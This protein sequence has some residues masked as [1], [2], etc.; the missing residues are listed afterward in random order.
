[1]LPKQSVLS[2][3]SP[4][5]WDYYVIAQLERDRSLLAVPTRGMRRRE[6]RGQDFSSPKIDRCWLTTASRRPNLDTS[7]PGYRQ[8][9]YPEQSRRARHK[10]LASSLKRFPARLSF[11]F[12]FGSKRLGMI[13]DNCKMEMREP[14]LKKESAGTLGVKEKASRGRRF[15]LRVLTDNN[16]KAES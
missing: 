9:H 14:K 12:L 7:V 10:S 3:A 16:P 4:D 15:I 11:H 1:V 2:S 8:Q 13:G 5:H 6:C